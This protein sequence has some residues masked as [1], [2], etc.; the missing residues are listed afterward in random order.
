MKKIL[1]LLLLFMLPFGLSAQT[2]DSAEKAFQDSDFATAKA[3]YQKLLPNISGSD[4]WLVQLRLAACEYQ[5]GAFL[6]AAKMMYGYS[7]PQDELW[8]ARFLLYRIQMANQVANT[9]RPILNKTQIDSAAAANDKEQWTRE[10]WQQQIDQDFRRLWELKEVLTVMPIEQE[11]VIINLKNTDTQRIPTL[12]DFTVQQWINYLQRNSTLSVAPI[13]ATAPTYLDGAARLK[14]GTSQATAKLISQIL[15]TASTLDGTNRQNAKLFWK[16]DAILQPFNNNSFVIENKEKALAD[17]IAD[18]RLI[19]GQETPKTSWWQR[20]KDSLSSAPSA[21]YGRSYAAWQLAQLQYQNNQKPQAVQTCEFALSQLPASYYTEQCEQLK[22]RI[23]QVELNVQ[24]GNTPFNRQQ[25]QLTFSGQNLTRVYA[26]VYP[27]S[28]DELTTLYRSHYNRR[29]VN[30]FGDVTHL[31]SKDVLTFAKRTPQHQTSI[32]VP[33]EEVGKA[34]TAT[35]SLPSLEPGFYVVLLADKKDFTADKTNIYGWV[36]NATDLALFASTAIQGD[37]TNFVAVRNAT[38]KTINPNVFHL[39]TINLKT[40]EIEPNTKLQ[41]ITDWNGTR[42]NAQ[43]NEEGL[44][45]T[46]RTVTVSPQERVNNQNYSLDVLASKNNS[47]TFTANRLYFN[48][49]N[50][51]PVQLFAQTDRPIYRP[52]QKA[53]LSVQALERLPRGYK[54]LSGSDAK[55]QVTDPNGKKILSA[56][57]PLNALGNAQTQLS[58]PENDLLGIYSVSISVT[59]SKRTYSTYHSF[60]VEEYKRPDYEVTLEQP[61]KPLEYGKKATLTGKARYYMGT[62]LEK[63][64]VNY[65]LKRRP[66]FPPFYWWWIRPISGEEKIIAQGKTSTDENGTFTVSFTPTRLEE[67]EEFANFILEAD[68]FDDSGRTISANRTYKI[69][70]HP[71]LVRV[72]FTQG[73]YDAQT[74]ASLA[75]IDLTDADGN[76]TSGNLTLRIEQLENRQ[77][78]PSMEQTYCYRCEESN[79]S[80]DALYKDV[81]AVKTVLTRTLSYRTPGAQ[82]VDLPALPEGIYRLELSADKAAKQQMVFVVADKKSALN[83]PDVALVQHKTYYP[84]EV[85]RV[86]VGAGNLRG[87][88]HIEVYQ[89]NQFLTHREVLP[90]GVSIF[91]MPLTQDHRGGVAMRWFGASDYVFH[92]AQTSAEVPFD[93]LQL[94]VT[95][96]IPATVKPGETVNWKITVKD[97]TA[98]AVNGLVNVTVYDKSLD[99]YAPNT[100]PLQFQQLYAQKTGTA[101]I[102]T[103]RVSPTTTGYY[104]PQKETEKRISLLPLPS[105]NLQPIWRAYG[106]TKSLGRGAAAPM[107]LMA[108]AKRSATADFAEEAI[109]ESAAMKDTATFGV[110]QSLQ[111]V[112]N[113]A[114]IQAPEQPNVRTDFSETA[115]FN[116]ALALTGGKAILR[117]TLPQSLTTWNILGFA[118]TPNV[119][120]GSFTASTVSQK[121]LMIRVQL[122]RYYREGDKGVLQAAVTN[123]SAKKIT[124]QVTLSVTKNGKTALSD[125]GISQPVK[126]VTVPANS[127][128]FVTW[129]ATAPNVPALYDIT[130]VVRNGKESDG[131]QKTLPVL[132][133]KMR[134]LASTHTALKNGANTLT[135]DELA[136]VPAQDIELAALTLNPSLALS[137]LNSMPNLLSS[138]YKDLVSSLNRY[139]PLAIVHQFYTTYP[140]L[141]EAVKK[142]PKR[143]GI[144]P[145]WDENDPLRLQL[146]EQTPWLRQAQGYK[147]R[148]ADIISLFDDNIVS[149]QLSKEQKNIAKLQNASGAFSWFAGG[150]DDDYLTLYALSS[151][152][153]ALSYQAQIPQAAAK[154]AFSYIVPKIEKRL[155]QDREGS[156]VSVSFALYAAYTLSAFPAHWPQVSEAKAAIKRWV[157]YADTQKKFMTPLGQIYAAAVYHRLGDDVKANHYL[158][159]VLARMKQDPLTGAYFAPEAQSWIWYNDTLSTQTVTL[160]TLLE[161]RPGSDK[162]APMLEWLLF[163]RQVNS[164]QNTKAA[165]QAVFTVLDVM[166]AQGALTK[167]SSYQV[168]WAGETIVKSFEPLDWTEDL[169]F[170]RT[171][172]QITPSS[173]RAQI[174][175]K[176]PQTDFASLNAVYLAHDVNASAKGVINVKREYFVRVKEAD[177]IK[178]RPVADV[179]SVRVGEELEVRLTLTTD[180]AFEYVLL[181]DP[182]PAGFESDA[183]TSGWDYQNISFYREIKDS[184]TN[185]FINWLP[186]GTVTLNYTLRPS[187]PGQLH[188]LPAQAQSMYA[189]E[190]GAHSASSSFTIEK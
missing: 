79:L 82:T 142:L 187:V 162:I 9:Y 10:Q 167:P 159:I 41:L 23:T 168:T 109:V 47:L 66:Y 1:S 158:D 73:F 139:V 113:E 16:T 122:P 3:E 179:S 90:G 106:A 26:R 188:A 115:Y 123:Q 108:N 13:S 40:G 102:R 101:D 124:T 77:V 70:A 148:S 134:L 164:W 185:F 64:T 163:N 150:P 135:L 89:D 19:T 98:S 75:K 173:Y 177:K 105:L 97:P 59:A 42:V 69:S 147:E 181:Q 25:P 27:T 57:V 107:M 95:P 44:F 76:S 38:P 151:F 14:E 7:L 53:H 39:Y 88:K 136:K 92:G 28:F 49:Y 62:P 65:T 126:T 4:K 118:V 85:L 169:Q 111:E 180:S 56:N 133:G 130:A 132:P 145:A 178:L 141:K 157:D 31:D 46:S 114:G 190:Y 2:L 36:V 143:T 149:A 87:T 18:L 104:Y 35:L 186:R 12:F 138:P 51:P 166:K 189:P 30:S 170:V 112:Q 80:L 20:L 60:R 125:F 128:Q 153:Q 22:N 117:F 81:S 172:K 121:D 37:P 78:T 58:L 83:L 184:A 110:N 29:T 155:K 152:A 71:Q 5:N 48:F 116:P 119:H 34:Q 45:D 68:V 182:K 52:G 74:P 17:A 8:Q 21:G 100:L 72:E 160:R 154:K 171:G 174:T 96:D 50:E 15:D 86:L 24:S 140:Q 120:F 67:D 61:Q 6:N 94:T 176:G 84:G 11:N 146:L 131:E 91:E 63:A 144:T 129:N 33:Y 175:K 54:T 161:M 156:V 32:E 43:T 55:F 165:T 93:N 103:S 127:T 99:Y 183:L 137:V